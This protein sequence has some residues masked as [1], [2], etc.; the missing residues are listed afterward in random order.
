MA[1][2]FINSIAASVLEEI[3]VSLAE[4]LC[5]DAHRA[6]KIGAQAFEEI[7]SSD[8]PVAHIAVPAGV[9]T[10]SSQAR[11]RTDV[12]CGFC[13]QLVCASRYAPHLDKCLS[14]AGL[15]K[16]NTIRRG[17]A[18]SRGSPVAATGKAA[19]ASSL[20]GKKRPLQGR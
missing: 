3:L 9:H 4:E 18:A 13:G 12:A 16:A 11:I 8:V 19:P 14:I 20:A 1:E 6:S 5:L 10:T 15:L 2:L 7:A 17:A